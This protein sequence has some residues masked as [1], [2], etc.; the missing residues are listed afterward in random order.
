MVFRKLLA[1]LGRTAGTQRPVWSLG[2]GRSACRRRRPSCARRPTSR[3]SP[4][5]PPGR[6]PGPRRPPR[7]GPVP[8]GCP[9]PRG[10]PRPGRAGGRRAGASSAGPTGTPKRRR[11]QPAHE[12]RLGPSTAAIV[13]AAEARGIPVRR[14]NAGSLVQLGHGRQA[15]AHPDGRDRPHRRHRRVDRPGQGADPRPAPRRRRARAR[16]PA[17]RPTPTT[18][19]RPPRRSARRSSSSRSTAT[20]AAASPPT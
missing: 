10:T 17:G 4:A 18:P 12:V 5:I 6:R 11:R 13:A 20:R 14:L 15:A 7:A 8:R 16:G 1:L 3:P 9:D 2:R 19:G